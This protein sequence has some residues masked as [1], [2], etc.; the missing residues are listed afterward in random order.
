MDGYRT[1]LGGEVKDRVG[2]EHEYRHP[3]DYREPVIDFALKA[4]EEAVEQCGVFDSERIP[5]ERWGVVIG[6]CNAGLLAGEEWYRR[7]REGKEAPSELLLLVSPQAVAES[8][9]SAFGFKGPVVSVNTACAA[10]ANAIGYAAELIREGHADAMLTGGTDALSDI[11]VAGFNALESLSPE[12]AAPYSLD[13]KGLSLGEG[14]SM[15]V[16]MSEDVARATGAPIL[17]EVDSYGLSADGYHPTAPHPE[18]K[19]ASRA[20]RTALAQGGVTG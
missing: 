15:L 8:L 11:L 14:G 3:D 17:A 10:S 2:P 19:G 5:R 7:R 1:K 13:R 12:P 16:L 18:G 4:S 6:S 9:S 20:I